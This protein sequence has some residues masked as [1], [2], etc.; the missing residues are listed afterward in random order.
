MVSKDKAVLS[1]ILLC[2]IFINHAE[3]SNQ[4]KTITAALEHGD[5]SINFRARQEYAAQKQLTSA[6]AYTIKSQL[7]YQ[8]ASFYQHNLSLE[9]VN[10]TSLFGQK[11]NPNADP[12]KK[13]N[14][15]I[16][17]DPKGTGITKANIYSEYLPNTDIILGRQFLSLDNSRMVGNDTF[18]Q[19]PT[20]FDA[21]T[22]KN[23]FLD[24]FEIFYSFVSHI[25]TSKNN[26]LNSDGRRKLLAN[27][28]N[29]TWQNFTYGKIVAYIYHNKDLTTLSNSN[30]TFGTRVTSDQTFKQI[31]NFDYELETAVQKNNC[32]NLNKYSAL[33][34]NMA[35]WK[36]SE[37]LFK[38]WLLT[39]K[40]GYELLG[41]H[42]TNNP[43][44][45]FIFPLGT[46]HGFNGLAEGYSTT[47]VR[48]L[49][50]YYA[51]INAEYLECLNLTGAIHIFQ[52]AKGSHDQYAG[53][54]TDLSVSFN[55]TKNLI[56]E[57]VFAKLNAKNHST[58]SV[59]RISGS[60][61]Y[62]VM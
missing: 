13:P 61:S 3:S 47:P 27:L 12:L 52:F 39:G 54:E 2:M 37:Q 48:G 19:F 22:I 46:L 21:I 41:S 42:D 62:S 51:S 18:R 9:M 5:P 59:N 4:Y 30:T 56:G 35:A 57:L 24:D 50:D 1:S 32:N 15:T 14:Y 58:K 6:Q 28:V 60:V 55:I 31:F 33:Y 17:S 45:S 26:S 11:Y 10:V 7:G 25:N 16:I 43:G 8:S 34:L 38:N 40:I 53:A 44:Y 36:D 29:V 20:S 49:K 23:N